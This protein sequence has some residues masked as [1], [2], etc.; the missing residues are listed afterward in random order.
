MTPRRSSRVEPTG[1][2]VRWRRRGHWRY[3]HL[4]LTPEQ[5]D[6]SLLVWD[7]YTGGARCLAPTRVQHQTRGPRGGR[8]WS[9]VVAPPAGPVAPPPPPWKRVEGRCELYNQLPLWGSLP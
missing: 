2:P 3:G 1:E 5:R 8:H 6:G 4:A 9:W 7:D